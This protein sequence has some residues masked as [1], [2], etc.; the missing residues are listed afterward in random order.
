LQWKHSAAP[1]WQRGWKP[2]VSCQ[3]RTGVD[4]G[5]RVGRQ[6]R[7][8]RNWA[9]NRRKERKWVCRK[10]WGKEGRAE[11]VNLFELKTSFIAHLTTTL[12][13]KKSQH[14]IYVYPVKWMQRFHCINDFLRN[15]LYFRS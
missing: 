12:D 6:E 5:W 11:K 14:K 7:S 2:H 15:A 8:T 10:G 1:F 9:E 13:T 3:L 4:D